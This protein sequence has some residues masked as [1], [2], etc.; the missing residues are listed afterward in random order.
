MPE[1]DAAKIVE[2]GRRLRGLTTPEAHASARRPRRS[3]P[4]VSITLRAA[5]LRK[6]LTQ[7]ELASKSGVRRETIARIEGGRRKI[8]AL[9]TARAVSAA[10]DLAPQEIDEFRA[11][12]GLS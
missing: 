10:L 2:G 5:R 11:S 12:L 9:R 6:A 4:G 1:M 3:A 8:V 7:A